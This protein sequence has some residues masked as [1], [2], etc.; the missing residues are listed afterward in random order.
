[1]AKKNIT[2]AQAVTIAA[3]AF[4]EGMEQAEQALTGIGFTSE[5]VSN[6]L[7]HMAKIRNKDGKGGKS[8]ENAQTAKK[9]VEWLAGKEPQTCADIMREFGL[10]SSAKV[11]IVLRDSVADGIITKGRADNGKVTYR[12]E[13]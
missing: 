3:L 9:I 2:E 11:S 4:I 7:A 12:I 6:K 13:G 5:D 10:K 1:M 8:I